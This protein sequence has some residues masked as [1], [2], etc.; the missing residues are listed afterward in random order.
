MRKLLLCAALL[1]GLTA[2]ALPSCWDL[3]LPPNTL[4]DINSHGAF[5]QVAPEGSQNFRGV[6]FGTDG[7]PV[8]I[9]NGTEIY[10]VTNVK[11]ISDAI[12]TDELWEPATDTDMNMSF[13]GAEVTDSES[14]T[15][16]T[17]TNKIIHIENNYSDAHL[18]ITTDD[19]ADYDSTL[20]PGVFNTATGYYPNVYDPAD[21]GETVFLDL[22]LSDCTG[23]VLWNYASNTFRSGSFTSDQ[24][25]I[26]G[27]CGADQFQ[28]AIL[29]QGNVLRINIGEGLWLYDANTDVFLQTSN[30]PAPAA[31]MSLF[32]G[33]ALLGG[34]R[35]RRRS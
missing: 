33:L 29:A 21:T 23:E 15:T 34:Y 28:Q 16:G 10:G 7:R 3:G 27:G 18:I 22:L 26:V 32:S 8:A 12:T 4:I 11:V 6:I 24:I 1:I 31:L 35:L 20:G 14:F 17:G 5:D 25:T 13:W 9:E 19:S 30:V 2:T